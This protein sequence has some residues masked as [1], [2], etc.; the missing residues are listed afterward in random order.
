LSV[1]IVVK[2]WPVTQVDKMFVP[3]I[4]PPS[5]NASPA[6]YIIEGKKAMSIAEIQ[7]PFNDMLILGIYLF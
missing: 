2:G 6:P 3:A 1:I 7:C 5:V 4:N